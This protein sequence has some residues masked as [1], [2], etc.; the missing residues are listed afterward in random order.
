MKKSTLLAGLGLAISLA[1]AGAASAGTPAPRSPRSTTSA[2][3]STTACQRRAH[4]RETRR[5][6]AGQVHL[7]RAERR[8]KPM[9]W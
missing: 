4:A 3:A 7:N 6:A 5:L 1:M 8:A 2:R 9:A